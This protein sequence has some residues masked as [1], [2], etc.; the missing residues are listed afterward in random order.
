[1]KAGDLI[2]KFEGMAAKAGPEEMA[3]IRQAADHH[4]SPPAQAVTFQQKPGDVGYRREAEW[5]EGST[6][7]SPPRHFDQVTSSNRVPVIKL[8]QGFG[9]DQHTAINHLTSAVEDHRQAIVRGHGE[10]IENRKS[11]DSLKLSNQALQA[12]VEAAN[13][14]ARSKK[15]LAYSALGTSV[16]TA[17]TAG[18]YQKVS[19]DRAKQQ[20]DSIGDL[21]EEVARLKAL[22]GRRI[23]TSVSGPAVVNQGVAGVSGQPVPGQGAGG[24]G[25]AGSFGGGAGGFGGGLV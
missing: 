13:K 24:D 18:L 12:E 19:S 2:E 20:A 11:I 9:S 21:Q 10:I 14:G 5:A 8:P 22:N 6:S 23:P 16:V 25:G 4:S 1:M 7:G 17:G 15:L 3:K